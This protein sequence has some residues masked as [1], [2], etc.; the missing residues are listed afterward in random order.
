MKKHLKDIQ[1][2]HN[3]I[4]K[5]FLEQQQKGSCTS[6]WDT[7]TNACQEDTKTATQKD[8]CWNDIQKQY[9][10]NLETIFTKTMGGF[11]QNDNPLPPETPPLD[12][13]FQDPEWQTNPMF[14]YLK[15]SYLL[16]SDYVQNLFEHEDLDA[17]SRK[18]LQFYIKNFL[19]ALSPSNFPFTN[20]E[21]VRETVKQKG[22]NLVKGFQNYLKDQQKH[23]GP[24]LPALTDLSAFKVGESLATT[25]GKVIFENEIFQ[26]IQYLPPKTPYYET[27]VLII[28]PWINKFYI[29]DLQPEK[30]FIRWNV[31]A[32]HVV[33]V[34]SWVNPDASYASVGLK[35]YLLKGIDKAIEKIKSTT[36][37]PKVNA[38]GFC[39][40][41]VALLTLMGY[42]Q[43]KGNTSIASATL[44]ASPTDFREMGDLSLFVSKEQIQILEKTLK[45]QGGLAGE[46]MMQI[47]RSLRANE[48]I[49]PNYIN[50]YLLGKKPTPLDFLFWNSDT[51][52]LPAKMHLEY[53]KEFF[54][55]NALMKSNEYHLGKVGIDIE[56]ITNPFFIVATQRDHIVPWKAA[57]PAFQKLRNSRFILG[58][59]GHIVGIINPPS[60]Q[61]YGYWT[62]ETPHTIS[63]EEWLH[64]ATKHAGSWWKEWQEWLT[65][66]LGQ[67]TLLPKDIKSPSLEDAPG[68]YALQ[69]APDLKVNPIA[70]FW[71]FY[72]PVKS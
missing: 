38:V 46:A 3:Q 60:G 7:I 17:E 35:D 23:Q 4:W 55:G 25:P 27:P 42:Y 13:R 47:F 18:K 8:I 20:P 67:R 53:L 19:D 69:K 2:F 10:E 66:Y 1:A 9:F 12:R 50:S 31:D 63:A 44:L 68:R 40:G 64:T 41:G 21:V 59:S 34:I 49:W 52:N 11:F 71:D 58:G 15:E 32:G 26:L 5:T 30:S 22:E 72:A 28:P 29:F 43:K 6:L 33:Y 54:L 48:L 14:Y 51:T 16:Y 56:T 39:V 61:K 62:N 70:G 57:F 65:P 37:V 36:H 24:A 45:K